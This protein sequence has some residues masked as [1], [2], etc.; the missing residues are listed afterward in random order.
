[1]LDLCQ[2]QDFQRHMSWSFLLEVRGGG[3]LF[4]LTLTELLTIAPFKLSFIVNVYDV[5]KVASDFRYV[6]G[7][8]RVLR[9]VYSSMLHGQYLGYGYLV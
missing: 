3:S 9:V 4:F 1:M 6:S 5:I 8:C 2:D 7:F